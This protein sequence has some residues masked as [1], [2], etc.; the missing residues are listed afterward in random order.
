[1]NKSHL[2]T[3]AKGRSDL[4]HL[5]LLCDKI[6]DGH[7]NAENHDHDKSSKKLPLGERND[8]DENSIT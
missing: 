1:M 7:I 5:G 2:E 3:E 8:V 4:C 6:Q